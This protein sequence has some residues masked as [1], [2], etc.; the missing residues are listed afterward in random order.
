ACR[1]GASRWRTRTRP[2]PWGCHRSG[3]RTRR[4]RPFDGFRCSSVH[5]PPTPTLPRKGGGRMTQRGRERLK[6]A[7]AD[8]RLPFDEEVP[9]RAG[10]AKHKGGH[11]IGFRAAVVQVVDGEEGDVGPLSDLD[12]ADVIASK[13]CGPAAGGGQ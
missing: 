13:A 8:D 12:G 7:V 5:R 1:R 11:R 9:H 4:S 6:L 10:V 2:S 3:A